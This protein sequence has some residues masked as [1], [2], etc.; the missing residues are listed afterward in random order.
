GFGDGIQLLGSDVA[1]ERA[2]PGDKM[3]VTLYWAARGRPS[4]SYTVFVHLLDELER[5]VVAGDAPPVSGT[6]PTSLW[7]DGDVISDSHQL[8]IDASTRPGSYQI[9]VGLYL[10]Q[11]GR[12]LPIIGQ[13]D[14]AVG[15]RLLLPG[16]HV[17]IE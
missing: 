8:T 4:A 2:R 7:D 11:D 6:Y 16:V 12:R 15:D 5:V 13:N 9:E 3:K 10:P 14:S 1:P 17:T